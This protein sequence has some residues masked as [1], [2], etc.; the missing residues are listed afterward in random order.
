MGLVAS[1]NAPS[2]S[3]K[4]V[5]PARNQ[6]LPTGPQTDEPFITDARYVERN[7]LR[8]GLVGRAEYLQCR[9]CGS[10]CGR[11][12]GHI[13]ISALGPMERLRPWISF[14]NESERESELEDLALARSAAARLVAQSG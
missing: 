8:A 5:I 4:R 9:V 1:H 14:V 12:E 13:T 10:F 2:S 6:R 7:A 3:V 11:T